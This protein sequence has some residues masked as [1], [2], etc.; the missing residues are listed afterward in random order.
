MESESLYG[1]DRRHVAV[2]SDTWPFAAGCH[3]SMKVTT[4][5]H[6]PHTFRRRNSSQQSAKNGSS[7]IETIVRTSFSILMGVKML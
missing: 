3:L 6:G 7:N 5:T 2:V 1:L 4:Y